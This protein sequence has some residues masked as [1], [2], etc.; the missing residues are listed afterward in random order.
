MTS[1]KKS[2]GKVCIMNQHIKRYY[3]VLCSFC[4][5]SIM[6]SL[7]NKQ[8]YRKYIKESGWK[9]GKYVTCPECVKKRLPERSMKLLQIR[10]PQTGVLIGHEDNDPGGFRY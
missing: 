4:P 3:R 8:D 2:R 7:S 10:D 6:K 9:F 1:Y 5:N